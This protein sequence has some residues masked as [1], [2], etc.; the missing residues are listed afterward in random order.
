MP[1]NRGARCGGVSHDHQRQDQGNTIGIMIICLV[2][3]PRYNCDCT[4]DHY[5]LVSSSL[6]LWNSIKF[7]KIQLICLICVALRRILNVCY[8]HLKLQIYTRG[9]HSND[10]CKT[11][12]QSI[13]IAWPGGACARFSLHQLVP[14]VPQMQA[15]EVGTLKA[16]K[17]LLRPVGSRSLDDLFWETRRGEKLWTVW[18]G[19]LIRGMGFVGVADSKVLGFRDAPRNP[20]TKNVQRKQFIQPGILLGKLG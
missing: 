19:K 9:T 6:S 18:E 1:P 14:T 12:D 17:H 11:I 16:Q 3:F 5:I 2:L 13:P 15:V 7:T 20:S 8:C 4:H 10:A